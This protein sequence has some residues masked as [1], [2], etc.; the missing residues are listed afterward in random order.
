[1]MKQCKLC[2][3]FKP[4][5]AFWFSEKKRY[6]TARCDECRHAQTKL[7]RDANREKIAK[8]VR[9]WQV[10]NP[11]KLTANWRRHLE[12][13]PGYTQRVAA[14]WRSDPSNVERHREGMKRRREELKQRVYDAYGGAHCNC[15]GETMRRFLTMD[16][17][18]NDGALHRRTI[19]GGKPS[20]RSLYAW[21]IASGF[22]PGFQVLCMNCNWGKARNGGVCPHQDLEG[23]EAI[24]SGSTLEVVTSASGSARH[25]YPCFAGVDEDDE[26]VRSAARVAAAEQA[27]K[28]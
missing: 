28:A 24:P 23:S 25:P 5:E 1:M 18:D 21:L 19:G 27:G 16:H 17:I 2:K 22:P 7:Y 15:C 20:S 13:N 8:Q 6:R 4:E 9:A 12:R 11:E 14:K 26:I 3:E 10:N